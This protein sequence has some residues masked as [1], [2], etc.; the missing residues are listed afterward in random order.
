MVLARRCVGLMADGHRLV[1]VLAGAGAR[2]GN[3]VKELF[4]RIWDRTDLD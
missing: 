4:E 2:V 3:V 1:A